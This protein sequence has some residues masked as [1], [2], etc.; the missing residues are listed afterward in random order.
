[1][2]TETPL[3][4]REKCFAIVFSLVLCS[5]IVEIG[6]RVL[7]PGYQRFN[8]MLSEYPDNPR[9]YFDVVHERDGH[10]LY[11]IRMNA[12]MGL[13]G[14]T[15]AP[16]VEP[17]TRRAWVLG[18]GDSQAQ[19]QGVRFGDTF[20]QQLSGLLSAEGIQ[21]GVRNASVSGYDLDEITARYAYETSD[22]AR[23][24]VVLYAMV[25]D[26]FGLDR[27]KLGGLDFIQYQ[28]G[29]TADPWR[30][31]SATYNFVRHIH[32]QWALSG[33]T[34]AAYQESFQ[35]AKMAAKMA[36]L[37]RLSAAVEADGGLFLVA[38]LPLLY[39]FEAYPFTGVHQA[40][41]EQA[42]AHGVPLLDLLPV[43]STHEAADL[44]VHPTDHHPNEI[45]H[46]LIAQA[47]ME[48]IAERGWVQRL[49]SR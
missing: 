17:D 19:G 16:G 35:G 9:G 41:V 1:M 22:G 37:Q 25:L 39:D 6:F 21:T 38:V 48:Q 13:G 44:W 23:Y 3:S 33:Q 18:L 26:D 7:G 49:Q 12:A 24:P 5:L 15:A 32:E 36:Q 42:A 46:T 47:L 4:A 27:D 40:L 28:P 31:R 30:V 45:A 14:R 11:G 43:L 34:T 8:N 29:Y 2:S 20:Y 10:T